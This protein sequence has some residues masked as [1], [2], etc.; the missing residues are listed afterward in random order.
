MWISLQIIGLAETIWICIV[1][2]MVSDGPQE[3]AEVQFSETFGTLFPCYETR[4]ENLGSSLFI[5]LELYQQFLL[6]TT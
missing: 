5:H 6:K 2:E 1:T 4:L 3:G